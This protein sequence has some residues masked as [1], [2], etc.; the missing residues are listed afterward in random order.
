MEFRGCPSRSQ[1]RVETESAV[2][3]IRALLL[4]PAVLLL[5]LGATPAQAGITWIEA[6]H[7]EAG[8]LPGTAQVTTGSMLIDSI[9]GSILGVDDIDVFKIYI[10][11]LS[12][13]SATT[14]SANTAVLDS[15]LFLFDSAGIGVAAN[16]DTDLFGT[17]ETNATLA[18]VTGPAG[19][20][21]LAV[22][23]YDDFPISGGGAIFPDLFTFASSGEVVGPTGPGGASAVIGWNA[24]GFSE[25]ASAYEILLRGVTPAATESVPEPNSL[26]FWLPLI[27]AAVATKIRQSEPVLKR[28]RLLWHCC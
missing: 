7:G 21:Y 5:L 11:D 12:Q 3:F 15:Q 22:S 6:D 9:Q 4:V 24:D 18:S 20:Y 16:G 17:G 28:V 26:A 14:V 25:T 19:F 27:A 2:T 10:A 8:D 13:F 1:S 23:L